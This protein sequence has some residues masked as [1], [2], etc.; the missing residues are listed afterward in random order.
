MV[1][2]GPHATTPRTANDSLDDL[3]RRDCPFVRACVRSC[4]RGP[5][6]LMGGRVRMRSIVGL[7]VAWM[8]VTAATAL[9]Q[10]GT[11]ITG[12]VVDAEA[13]AAIPA[14]TVA[15]TGAGVGTLTSDSGTFVLH[16][17]TSARSLTVR[18]IGY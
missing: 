6:L 1:G 14:V 18:R 13:K 5:V 3:V 4:R 17:P 7:S 12:R 8:A 9:G 11:R 16:L 2:C 15:A 10:E